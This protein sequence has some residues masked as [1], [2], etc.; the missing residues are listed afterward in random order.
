MS[1]KA[2]SDWSVQR[3]KTIEGNIH[4]WTIERPGP[5][6]GVSVGLGIY[7]EPKYYDVYLFNGA[8]G[9]NDPELGS[10]DSLDNA[11]LFAKAFMN[12]IN[13]W[14]KFDRYFNTH[15]LNEQW[16]DLIAASTY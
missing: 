4:E 13:T 10:F 16:N 15:G 14:A 6:I 12:D 7:K 3:E 1:C 11:V 8:F 2:T 9:G 5:G